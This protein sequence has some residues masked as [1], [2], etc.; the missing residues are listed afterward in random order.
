MRAAVDADL[1]EVAPGSVAV[2]AIDV[3][4]TSD[5]IDAVGA[6]VIGIDEQ[7]VEARPKLLPLFPDAR[8]RM[9]L[10]LDVPATFPAGRRQVAVELQSHGAREPSLLLDLNLDVSA[11]PSLQIVATPRLVRTRRQARFVLQLTN[12]GNVALDVNLRASDAD[13]ACECQF[14]QDTVRVDAGTTVALFLNVRCPRRITGGD[15]DR[16]ITVDAVSTRLDLPPDTPPTDSDQ[17]GTRSAYVQVHQR[18]LISRGLMTFLVLASIVA[19]WA[20][21]FLLGIAKVF[22]SDP[23]TKDAPASFFVKANAG[24]AGFA[25]DGSGAHAPAGT[26]PKSGQVPAGIGAQITGT[27]YAKSDRLPVGR[28][29]VQA[30]RIKNGKQDVVS[31]A[32]TQTDG[33]YTLAG[34][35]PIPYYVSFSAPGFKTVWYPSA[36]S[37]LTAQ[38]VATVAQVTSDHINTVIGGLPASIKGTVKPGGALTQVPTTVTANPLVG[39]GKAVV[40]HT[41]A[42]GNYV[43]RNLPAPGAYELTFKAKDYQTTALTESVNGGEAR[44][45]PLVTLGAGNGKIIGKVTSG[46]TAVGGATVATTVNGKPLSV[47]TPTTGSVGTF[48]LD[49]LLTPATYVITVTA[50]GFGSNTK[51]VSLEPGKSDTSVTVSLTAGTGTVTG[52]V[53]TQSGHKLGGAK[54]TIGG[55]TTASGGSPTTTTLTAGSVGTFSVNGLIAPGSYTV[56]AELDGY[57]PATVPFVLET[58]NSGAATVVIKL[59]QNVGSIGGTVSGSCAQPGCVGATVSVTDGANTWTVKV[60]APGGPIKKHAGYLVTG[61]HPGSYSVTVSEAGLQQETALVTVTAG[62]TAPQNFRLVRS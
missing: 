27:V 35:F 61:L 48:E 34:L 46:G 31:S 13:R 1:L 57:A 23:I 50:P 15:F 47:I 8:G 5:V 16:A 12:D 44:I 39:N 45:E 32:A 24:T 29:L 52:V 55:A 49:N 51:I 21:A 58:D 6:R 20:G 37:Y 41:D 43:L 60:S 54:I 36:P 30:V 25:G 14:S 17:V 56:T 9:T 38:L 22:A 53:E 10:S 4:N 18:P 33:T 42:S 2:V 26:I 62:S 40:A 19:L 11:H 3:A 28:I 7:F 59:S